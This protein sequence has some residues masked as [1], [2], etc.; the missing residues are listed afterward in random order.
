M[1]IETANTTAAT[2]SPALATG[3]MKAFLLAHPVGM[4]VVGATLIGAGTYYL[5]KKFSN[6]K[7][8]PA[9]VVMEL[10]DMR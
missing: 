9:P 6:K 8:E 5:I 10:T 1:A 3:S 4:A 2:T 7:E